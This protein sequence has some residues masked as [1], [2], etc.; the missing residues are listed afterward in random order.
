MG[1]DMAAHDHHMMDGG[2]MSMVAM[3][4][5]LPRSRD[6]LPME[7]TETA[8]GPLFPGLPAGL[9]V[10]L[11]LDGDTVAAA[12]LDAGHVHR[13]I[14]TSLSGPAA[15]LA[16]RLAALDPLAPVAYRVLAAKALA[17]VQGP[18]GP[19]TVDRAG[20]GAVERERATSH[21]AWLAAFLDLLGAAA[22]AERAVRLQLK[23]AQASDVATMHG[24][25]PKIERLLRDVARTPLLGPRTA[26]IGRL[27]P[28]AVRHASGPVAR[29]SGQPTDA[30][31][32]SAAYRALGFAPVTR[33][34]GD[35]HARLQVRLAEIIQ[36]LDL[37]EASGT[38]G[39][40]LPMGPAH[41]SGSGVATVET[42]RGTASLHV[43]VHHG[44][45]HQAHPG[46]PSS[47]L[48]PLVPIVVDQA[49]LADALV[50]IASLDLSPWDLD[51]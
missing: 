35:V 1:H 2:F 3:T 44:Q 41:L 46:T 40:T 7:W 18:D 43:V 15:T 14:V 19:D 32:E 9:A 20:I 28:D 5:D 51:Q 11:T 22:L 10:M 38:I 6:G 42:P 33:E 16:D 47:A 29:A 36:S 23:A 50:A 24:L 27:A 25:R 12:E 4:Q 39:L 8:F 37:I 17:A 49:E 45:V 30:R 13:D 21:L 31:A 26:G 48:G 34:R